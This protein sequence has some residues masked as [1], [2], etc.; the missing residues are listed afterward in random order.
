MQRRADLRRQSVPVT[1]DADLTS[2]ARAPASL[3]ADWY[4]PGLLV[5]G[6]AAT[7]TLVELFRPLR[8]PPR[9]PKVRHAGRNLAV[10]GLAAV[11]VQLL[12]QPIVMPLARVVERRRWG[13]LQALGLPPWL[14]SIVA[15]AALDYTLYVWHVLV[16]RTPALWRFHAVHHVDLDLDASTAVRFHFGELVASV[17]WRAAQIAIIGVGPQTL[18]TWQTLTLLS[19]LFHHSNVRLPPRLE[20]ALGLIIVTPRMHGIH[21]S[22]DASEMAA[23]WSSGLSVWDRLHGT[24]RLDVPQDRIRIGVPGQ[25]DEREVGLARIIA[26]PFVEQPPVPAPGTS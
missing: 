8:R 11:A 15:L 22:Q 10:A 16:H 5:I 6:V 23:N 26:Q 9:E 12:E 2:R 3:G 17:P 13:L 21:H 7:L 19:V 4:V 25:D 20:R 1:D 14:R 24:S 18:R